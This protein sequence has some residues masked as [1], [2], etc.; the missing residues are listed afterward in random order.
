MVTNVDKTIDSM[1]ALRNPSSNLDLS[2]STSEQTPVSGFGDSLLNS[3][4][5]ES[6]DPKIIDGLQT[7]ATAPGV[8]STEIGR[9]SDGQL[10]GSLADLQLREV[11]EAAEESSGVSFSV[12]QDNESP[13]PPPPPPMLD[14][15]KYFSVSDDTTLG[16][17]KYYSLPENS[18]DST[19]SAASNYYSNNLSN[20]VDDDTSYLQPRTD[21]YSEDSAESLPLES[22]NSDSDQTSN[23]HVSETGSNLQPAGSEENG[24][25]SGSKENHSENNLVDS[26]EYSD[27]GNDLNSGSGYNSESESESSNGQDGGVLGLHEG[28]ESVE[29]NSI[30]PETSSV[31]F[32]SGESITIFL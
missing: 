27:A 9:S 32:E 11:L 20:F 4:E 6:L 16:S 29:N 5:A 13:P 12:G 14:S 19:N 18:D 23:H 3:P 30:P 25:P 2:T 21:F 1:K 22:S 15:P 31:P 10:Q 8:K 26:G 24:L 17:P 7:V 28:E